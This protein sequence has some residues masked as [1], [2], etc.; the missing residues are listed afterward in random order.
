ML[1][2]RHPLYFVAFYIVSLEKNYINLHDFR[3]LDDYVE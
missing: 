2:R 3:I 1:H